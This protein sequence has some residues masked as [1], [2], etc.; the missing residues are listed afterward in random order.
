[1]KNLLFLAALLCALLSVSAN[2]SFTIGSNQYL[3]IFA[4]PH[5]LLR[6]PANGFYFNYSS[7]KLPWHGNVTDVF[8]R[9]SDSYVNNYQAIDFAPPY[10]YEGDPA[11]VASWMMISGYAKSRYYGFGGLQTTSIGKFLGEIGITSLRMKLNSEGVARADEGGVY[12]LVPYR[13]EVKGAQYDLDGK[14]IFAR[15]LYGNPFGFKIR[16]I[17]KDAVD[18]TGYLE[19]RRGD[20]FVRTNHLTWGW[21]N[22][23]CSHIMGYS[24][25][26]ADAFYQDSYS[27]ISMNRFDLQSSYEFNGNYKSGIRYR[28]VTEKGDNY[29]W[30]YNEGSDIEGSYVKDETWKTKNSEN[31][32]RAYSKARFIE[33][34]NMGAGI[35]FF[36][37]YGTQSD[38][39]V[40]HITGQESD[41]RDGGRQ[42][43]IETNPF[44]N[45]KFDRGYIDFGIL[46]E[47]AYTR[48]KN[49]RS[50]WN[51]STS[52]EEEK[53]LRSSSPFQG[54]S[55]SWE[56][57]SK[58][59]DVFFATGCE[60][61]SSINIYKRMSFQAGITF[62]KK[63]S[64]LH[65][66]Y[67]NSYVPESGGEYE[68]DKTHIRNTN[69]NE[70]WMTGSLGLT[71]G[72]G[73]VQFI[74]I[75]QLPLA[76]LNRRK[77]SL[78]SE[79]ATLFEHE[80]RNV[81]QVQ[82]PAMLRLLVVCSLG[83]SSGHPSK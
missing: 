51:E 31:F 39:Q 24:H 22:L 25:I 10:G 83:K 9:P 40:N 76:Y 30:Q 4:Y 35:L 23:S 54:W 13:S 34:G 81:W 56:N 82:K 44:F 55:T 65:K 15:Q 71:Y 69:K 59:H 46:V 1:M 12:T 57:F 6:W 60:T 38:R 70:T 50:A 66:V 11:A 67:G 72:K 45:L 78:D 73:P 79:S 75:I 7:Q 53:V 14:V 32:I 80:K 26:N 37:Q 28:S 5:E 61:Y 62:L 27:V 8:A 18:P 2:P 19:F 29:N 63:F 77:T 64:N 58:G 41:A 74:S 16:Y 36:V 42:Y 52:S 48:L 68:F 47:G 43:I 49:T 3:T 33:H 21:S 17:R 20:Q